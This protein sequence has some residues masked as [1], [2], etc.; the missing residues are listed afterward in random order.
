MVSRFDSS[1]KLHLFFT[2]S[3]IKLLLTYELNQ[4]DVLAHTFIKKKPSQKHSRL[5]FHSLV[6]NHPEF[7]FFAR[8]IKYKKVENISP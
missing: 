2:S 1:K 6:K 8:Y 3:Y 5:V 7:L 4:F